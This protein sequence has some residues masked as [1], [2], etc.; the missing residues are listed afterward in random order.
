M[1]DEGRR[2]GPYRDTVGKLTIGYGRNLDD[3][4]ISQHEAE[5][6]LESDINR[7]LEALHKA[8][9]WVEKLDHARLGVL[10]NMAFNLGVAGLLK[11]KHTLESVQAGR[12]DEASDGMLNSTWAGQVKGRATRLA[13]QMR[14]GLW[15]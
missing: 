12:Y 5:V 3:V 2:L 14:S 8:L 10:A 6:L 13:E 1:R 15:Q 4:G 7:T 11:F 9:P